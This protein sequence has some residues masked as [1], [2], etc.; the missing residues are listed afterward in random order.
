MVNIKLDDTA[1][2]VVAKALNL[3][4]ASMFDNWIM[5]TG[6][7]SDMLQ[8][9]YE[10]KKIT[11]IDLLPLFTKY[12]EVYKYET[13]LSCYVLLHRLEE[14][15]WETNEIVLKFSSDKDGICLSVGN[16]IDDDSAYKTTK[17]S[18]P[19]GATVEE[20]IDLVCKSISSE[21]LSNL[22]ENLTNKI[23]SMAGT[24]PNYVQRN[25]C[26]EIS[27]TSGTFIERPISMKDLFAV[28]GIALD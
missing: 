2:D 11:K 20:T 15:S 12:R 18:V 14:F 24:G 22:V 7:V 17:I 19:E 4:S 8:D 23:S 10:E 25:V 5:P 16:S 1:K 6:L 21:D 28:F 3:G 9:A 26:I 13:R 27:D